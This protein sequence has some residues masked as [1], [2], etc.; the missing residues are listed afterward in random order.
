V[1]LSVSLWLVL[2]AG[3]GSGAVMIRRR[4]ARA[5]DRDPADGEGLPTA[6]DGRRPL[7]AWLA[8]LVVLFCVATMPAWRSGTATIYGENPDAHQVAGIAVL[9]QHVP[10]TGTDI[11]LPVDTVPPAWRFRYPIFYPL[12]GASNLAHMDPMRVFPAMAAVL[13]VIAA[14]GFGALAVTCLRAPRQAGPVVAAAVGLSAP[15]RRFARPPF[16]RNP[17]VVQNDEFAVRRIVWPARLST[18]PDTSSQRLVEP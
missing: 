9:F 4:R 8:V 14:L 2:A 13:V 17:P 5:T 18:V 15:P 10:P 1:P 16:S 12:A 6:G 11:R 3:L 7:G